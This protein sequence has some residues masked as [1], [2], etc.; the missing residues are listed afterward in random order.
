VAAGATIDF[1]ALRAGDP[2]R[3]PLLLL[4]GFLGEARDYAGLMDRLADEFYCI[5]V[6]L[7]GHGRHEF[8]AE[9]CS[10]P[11]CAQAL[12]AW[13]ARQGIERPA[14]FGY[15][16][17]GRLALR[18]ALAHP[19]A[20]RIAIAESA[21]PGLADPRARAARR[22]ADATLARRL[23]TES[24]RAFLAGWYAQPLFE[25]LAAHAS[26]PA[27]LARRLRQDPEGLA[28]SLETMGTGAQPS[29]WS[30]LARLRMPLRLIVGERDGKFREIAAQM[31]AANAAIE[32]HVIPGAG[33]NAHVE[34]AG[35]FEA[36]LREL[37]SREH[38]GEP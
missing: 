14:V 30:D 27:M 24:L 10:L 22:E 35:A 4:H 29:L 26:F 28:R 16:M 6:D 18:L 13:L 11:A 36:R 38:R 20:F 2:A 19:E 34:Q 33:H 7:P 3:P 25:G 15:S 1:P 8:V 21:S 23:R 12:V 31:A 9:G 17:G 32:V 37:L 5:A